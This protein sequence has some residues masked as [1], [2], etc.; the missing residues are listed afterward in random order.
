MVTFHKNISFT[1]YAS[2]IRL[3]DCSKLAVNWKND[4]DVTLYWYAAIVILLIHCYFTDT[5]LICRH[6][7]FMT[8]YFYK[9]LTRYLEIRNTPIWVLPNIWRLTRVRNTKFGT[10]VSNKLLL[11]AAKCQRYSFCRSWVIRVKLTGGVTEDATEGSFEDTPNSVL[12]DL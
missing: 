2:K 4:N 8:I 9:G 3:A 5:L 11:K 6:C 10:D 1:D 12:W 7:W